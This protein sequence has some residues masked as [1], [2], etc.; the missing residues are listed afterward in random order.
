MHAL[1]NG[2]NSFDRA[3]GLADRGQWRPQA[4]E[5]LGNSV[6]AGDIHFSAASPPKCTT[7]EQYAGKCVFER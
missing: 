3:S 2:I 4:Q 7:E 5:E 1:K 6:D